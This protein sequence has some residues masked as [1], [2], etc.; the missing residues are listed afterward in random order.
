MTNSLRKYVI[1]CFILKIIKIKTNLLI[2]IKI[3][4]ENIENLTNYKNWRRFNKIVNFITSIVNKIK[5]SYDKFK[6]ISK[7]INKRINFRIIR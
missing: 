3:Y 1:K 2:N 7:L 4:F 5:N 6:I